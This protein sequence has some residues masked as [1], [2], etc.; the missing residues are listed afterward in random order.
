[1]TLDDDGFPDTPTEEMRQNFYI[2]LVSG[3]IKYVDDDLQYVNITELELESVLLNKPFLKRLINEL[4]DK[5]NIIMPTLTV[6]KETLVWT[7]ANV[8][9]FTAYVPKPD[10]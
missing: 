6:N 8:G 1:M 10:N 3:D 4:A 2:S 7:D 9:S 5:K